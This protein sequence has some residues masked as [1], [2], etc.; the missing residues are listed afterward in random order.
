MGKQILLA[1]TASVALA[2]ASQ[3]YIVAACALG[4]V[5]LPWAW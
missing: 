1:L 3:V 5:V 2:A 4:K